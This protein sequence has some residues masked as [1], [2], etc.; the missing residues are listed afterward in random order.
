MLSERTHRE[1]SFYKEND[2]PAV[3]IDYS[4][5]FVRLLDFV[6]LHRRAESSVYVNCTMG[7]FFRRG[8]VVSARLLHLVHIIE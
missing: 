3:R 2:E 4:S 7:L 1:R 5:T 8:K 6:Y